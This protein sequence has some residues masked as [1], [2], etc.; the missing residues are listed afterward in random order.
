[1]WEVQHEYQ[2]YFATN[3]NSKN[4][5]DKYN[6]LIWPGLCLTLD[7]IDA[8]NAVNF[9]WKATNK[10]ARENRVT[11]KEWNLLFEK[12][13]EKGVDAKQHV[14]NG[15]ERFGPNT[16]TDYYNEDKLVRLWEADDND[17]NDW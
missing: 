9:E 14:F 10:Q 12:M 17:D 4:N 16:T 3:E 6:V 7:Q 5:N 13:R 8:L 15:Q 2:T 1:M 11:D